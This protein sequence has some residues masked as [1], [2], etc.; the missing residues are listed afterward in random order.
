MMRKLFTLS[1]IVAIAFAL[2]AGCSSPGND[3]SA[4]SSPTAVR[5]DQA[6]HSLLGLYQ[7]TID[8][9]A[10]TVDAVPIRSAD[11][12]LNALVFLEPPPLLNL[13]IDNLQFDGNI[14][15]VDVG[16]RHPFLGFTEFTGFDVCGI[17]I[18][19]GSIAGYGDAALRVPGENDLRLLNP[20]G[21]TRWWN[22]AEFPVNTGGMLGYKDG[23]L[24]TPD[25]QAN[26][27]AT[28]NGYKYFCDDLDDPE[29]P[30]TGINFANR[31]MFG[32]GNKN[33]R[34][35]KIEMG[36]KG[37]VFNYAVDASWMPPTGTPPWQAP[38]DFP[39]G[40]NRPEA[41]FVSAGIEEN[42]LWNDGTGSGGHLILKVDVY[43][44][45]NV[46]LNTLSIESPGNFI[47]LLNAAPTETS[48]HIATYHY[49]TGG[50][51]PAQDSID[52]LFSAKCEAS[53]YDGLLPGKA[54]A[55]YTTLKVPVSPEPLAPQEF[56]G[57][58]GFGYNAE[59]ISSNV[60]PQ[61]FDPYS[62]TQKWY[63]PDDC[64][65][66]TGLVISETHVF[67]SSSNG[68]YS[69]DE[70]HVRCYDITDGS[71]KWTNNINPTGAGDG[72]YFAD[73][74]P[75][76]F[77]EYNVGKIVIGGDRVWCFSAVSGLKLW[78]Y[79][80]AGFDF[81]QS[82][83]KFYDGK[84]Y[85]T[86]ETQPSDG[87]SRLH[88]I[89]ASSGEGIWMSDPTKCDT[90]SVPA[91]KDGKVYWGVAGTIYCY[92]ADTGGFVWQ[93]NHGGSRYD[94]ITILGNRLYLVQFDEDLI[95]LDITDGHLVWAWHENI[96]MQPKQHQFASVLTYWYDPT[97]DLPVI[98]FRSEQLGGVHAVKDLG[99]KP[100]FL[101][102]W[103]WL[104]K[105]VLGSPI[106]NN[107]V[108][109]FCEGVTDTFLGL[110]ISSGKEVF[111]AKINGGPS[112]YGSYGQ[113]G[114]A[115]DKLVIAAV[116]G[117]YCFE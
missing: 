21:F 115:Y 85:I 57:W 32:A 84:I 1:A 62:C 47:A 89:N 106:Y 2:S 99:A 86:G 34:H 71:T 3:I 33:T 41:W 29:D 91:C 52:V 73:T 108:V 30:V 8:K 39:P 96:H 83:P 50:A 44:W 22:P 88:C 109:Y 90:Y 67:A 38:D 70:H 79:G 51:T 78:E 48:E 110:D 93:T 82:P 14:I 66:R 35:Y 42:S 55:I 102:T 40:A 24:G 25:S 16:L 60:Y 43:D 101:W 113:A 19:D 112:S 31:G 46:E 63:A 98:C 36:G 116:D 27:S 80:E 68:T 72:K 103:G 5:G 77:V 97:D 4:P 74:S 100:Q 9:A 53:G 76:Y 107:G 23:L 92:D 114:M 117:L 111:W 49:D 105:S 75:C 81:C 7:F 15:D 95:C 104:T 64:T 12:H 45:N 13:S 20:D 69:N 61:A 10:G 65:N 37:L 58:A 18:S 59:N 11:I 54:Q 94:C 26:F 28:L 56:K 6:S 17:L 87:Q